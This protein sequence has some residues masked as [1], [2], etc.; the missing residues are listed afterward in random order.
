MVLCV[1]CFCRI[2]Q[3][4]QVKLT[5]VYTSLNPLDPKTYVNLGEPLQNLLTLDP[6]NAVFY[7]GGYPD[8]FTV[9]VDTS[10]VGFPDLD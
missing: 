2:Y 3:D 4:A 5:K 10:W 8:D 1:R 6:N 7:V 9:S